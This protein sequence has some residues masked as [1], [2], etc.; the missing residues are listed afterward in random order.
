MLDKRLTDLFIGKEKALE[1][2][3]ERYNSLSDEQRKEYDDYVF[4]NPELKGGDLYTELNHFIYGNRKIEHFFDDNKI[5]MFTRI[6]LQHL[7][8]T[9]KDDDPLSKKIM[10]LKK[11]NSHDLIKTVLEHIKTYPITEQQIR[12]LSDEKYYNEFEHKMSELLI[13]KCQEEYYDVAVRSTIG[14]DID[15]NI[16]MI[17][18]LKSTDR[19]DFSFDEIMNVAYCIRCNE[20]YHKKM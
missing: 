13:S 2:V 18:F 17:E 12:Y 1:Y 20:D 11:I 7:V 5:D 4:N 3:Q 14:L 8:R 15:M 6:N 10:E 16:K 19:K 9:L